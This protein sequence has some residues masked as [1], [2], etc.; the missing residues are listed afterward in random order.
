MSRGLRSPLPTADRTPSGCPGP[1]PGIR[2]GF[3][4]PGRVARSDGRAVEPPLPPMR[5]RGRRLCHPRRSRLRTGRRRP[6]SAA[7]PVSPRPARDRPRRATPRAGWASTPSPATGRATPTSTDDDAGRRRRRTSGRGAGPRRPPTG[8]RAYSGNGG[9]DVATTTST[10]RGTRTPAHG[11]H[12][13]HDRQPPSRP[14][15][16]S[17]LDLVDLDVDDVTVDGEPDPAERRRA[18]P[19][20]DPARAAGRGDLPGRWSPDGTPLTRRRR[21]GRPGLVRPTA[22]RCNLVFEPDGAATLFPVNDHPDR[23]GDLRASGSPAPRASTWRPTAAHGDGARRRVATWVLEAPDPMASYL[24][25]VVIADLE[26]EETTGPGGLPIRTPSTPTWPRRRPAVDRIGEMIDFYDDLFGPYPFG[27][28]GAVVVDVPLG[29][30]LETRRCRSSAPT[31]PRRDDR[32]PRA[33]PPVVRRRRQPGHLAGHLAQRG[34]A[35]YASGCGPER[36][37]G[38]PGRGRW[39]SVGRRPGGLD[40]RRPTPGAERPVR[41]SV[42]ERAR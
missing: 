37:A 30:A 23:Q 35:T 27:A 14:R 3:L 7:R 4:P 29:V 11:G 18:R 40:R 5:R 16:A 24:V 36:R 33:G 2:D 34:F 39:E 19:G 13:H 22:T 12:G 38:R 41:G 42:Y 1:G 31:R 10:C 9:Y 26:F 25:Q 28:Y 6:P 15:R 17:A 32:G 8:G 20:G 21:P